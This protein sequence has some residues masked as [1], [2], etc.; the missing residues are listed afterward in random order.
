M[1][2]TAIIQARMSSKRLSGKVLLEI[3]NKPL[4]EYLIDRIKQ[5]R[6]VNRIIIATSTDKSDL[7][8]ANYCKQKKIECFRG[9]LA[10]VAERFKAV[11]EHYRIPFFLRICADSPLSDPVLIDNGVKNFSDGD[12]DIVTNTFKRTF[13]RGVSF[14]ILRSELFL[15][16]YPFMKGQDELE[17]V[18]AYFYKN[19]NKFR[20]CNVDTEG[21]DYSWI[22]LSVDTRDDF[23]L[24]KSI[25]KKIN[26]SFEDCRWDEL[27]RIYISLKG[28]G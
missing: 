7:P 14:E 23:N 18:T 24:I 16:H 8:I 6:T 19:F 10:N 25:M 12:Y 11:I 20:I 17:H 27:A 21:P 15:S 2:I 28:N 9:P 4:V 22:N 5:S 13:P 3:N 26:G 1:K